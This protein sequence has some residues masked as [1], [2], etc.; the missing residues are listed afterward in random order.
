[1]NLVP[2]AR[3]LPKA[4][5]R[6]LAKL[7]AAVQAGGVGTGPVMDALLST[8]RAAFLAPSLAV[9]A[10]DDACLPIGEGQT[11]SMP[12]VVARMT[13]AL[14]LTGRETVLEIGTGC[15]YQAA[16]LAKLA[17][18]VI[19]IERHAALSAGAVQ[20][21]AA[22]GHT[23]VTAVVGDG[24]LGWPQQAPFR[25][26]IVTAAGPQVPP[27]LVAQLAPGGRLVIPVGAQDTTQRLLRV[28]K[29]ADGVVT[30]EDLGPVVFVPLVGAQG[31]A[32]SGKTAMR[33]RA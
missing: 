25:A 7:Q 30:H 29:D 1:M 22:L 11:I 10:Y 6:Q 14:Q 21:L 15:G 17:R 18:R 12:S 2:F 33:Q 13:H 4:E 5:P 26:M 32:A 3:L 24:T 16:I 8:P 20:R 28:T 19:T 31:V 9:Q 23:N 27:A